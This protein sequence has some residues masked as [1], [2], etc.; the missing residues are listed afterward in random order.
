MEAVYQQ[1]VFQF[2]EM[3]ENDFKCN[4]CQFVDILKSIQLS[5]KTNFLEA[6]FKG[7]AFAQTLN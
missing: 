7:I 1:F 6:I 4:L 2:V 5:M 3:T